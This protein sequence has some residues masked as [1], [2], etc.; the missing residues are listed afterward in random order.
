MKNFVLLLMISV[1]LTSCIVVQSSDPYS[2][3]SYKNVYKP[4][5]V[6]RTRGEITYFNLHGITRIRAIDVPIEI[7]KSHKQ[8]LEAQS[9]YMKYL[10]VMRF[11]D[12]LLIFYEFPG[13][14]PDSGFHSMKHHLT[15]HINQPLTGLTAEG[16]GRI[17]VRDL[18]FTPELHVLLNGGTI[19]CDVNTPFLSIQGNQA[20]IFKGWTEASQ[21]EVSLNNAAVANLGGVAENLKISTRQASVFNGRDLHGIQVKVS[22]TDRS[23]VN[24]A[25]QETLNAQVSSKAR[26]FYHPL[27]DIKITQNVLGHGIVEEF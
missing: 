1:V 19:K 12:E 20:G 2:P 5:P 4:V 24:I 25:V 6:N 21:M 23:R 16:N 14:G 8:E 26:L 18:L 27:S 11:R 10:K 15:I 13:T 22:A 17:T 3:E 7:I 9:N